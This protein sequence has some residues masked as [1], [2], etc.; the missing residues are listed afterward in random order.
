VVSTN[1]QDG[2][3]TIRW[4][5]VTSVPPGFPSARINVVKYEILVDPFVDIFLPGTATELKLPDAGRRRVG[6][7]AASDRGAR[8]RRDRNQDDHGGDARPV[9]QR[10]LRLSMSDRMSQRP[11]A[12]P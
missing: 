7:G 9:A 1:V 5:P 8:D 11:F 2:H 10:R 6:R 12:S 4:E 3:A